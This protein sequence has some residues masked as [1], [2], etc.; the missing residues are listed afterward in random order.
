MTIL[1]TI[2]SHKYQ[3]VDQLKAVVDMQD[4]RRLAAQ[5]PLPRDL[6]AAIR[7][8]PHVPIIAE[9]KRASP[10]AGTIKELGDV[11]GQ[12]RL[13][14]EG[15][16]VALSVLTD[17]RFFQ[18]TL[19]DLTL[20]REAV[21]LPVLRKDFVVDPV[22]L[23]GARMAGADAVLLIAAALSPSTMRELFDETL[24]LGMT[25]VVEVHCAEELK[26][27]LPL[28]PPIVGINNRDLRSMEVHL[29][30]CLKLRPLVPPGSLVLAE[31]GIRSTDD[32]ARLRRGGVDAFLIGTTLMK[33]ADP[34]ETLARL[35]RS[36]S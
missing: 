22:Q 36:G 4:V 11:P 25:P 29:E 1:D 13:Y 19:D 16:A 15:G 17:F 18:G 26:G 9:I 32:I 31:S 34:S 12:A 24:R 28:D 23:Y 27:V 2:L 5:A 20:A 8:C 3:E 35:C 6:V 33:S 14:E 21:N 10:S 30:T 7:A